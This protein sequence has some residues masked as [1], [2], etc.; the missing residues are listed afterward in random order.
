MHSN[1]KA[2]SRRDG[3]VNPNL[4]VRAPN[5]LEVLNFGRPGPKKAQGF[6]VEPTMNNPEFELGIALVKVISVLGLL[7]PL[8]PYTRFSFLEYTEFPFTLRPF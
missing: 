4:L 3:N 2:L 5:N 1:T 8:S 6:D 7:V